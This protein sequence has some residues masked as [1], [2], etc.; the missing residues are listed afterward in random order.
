MQINTDKINFL[1]GDE[2][3]LCSIQYNPALPMFSDKMLGFLEDL[4]R[5]LMDD[6]RSRSYQ[7]VMS[8]AYW[9]RKSSLERIKKSYNTKLARIGRGVSFHIAPSNVPINFAVSM[10]SALLAGNSIVIRVSDKDYEQVSIVCDAMN[11]LLSGKHASVRDYFCIVRYPH[12]DEITSQ[13]SAMCDIRII[14]GGDETIRRIRSAA[15]PPR[16][17]EMTFAD[18]HSIALIDSDYYMSADKKEVAKGFFTDTYYT[19]Q[20]ACSSPRLVVWFGDRIE[21]A[22]ESFWKELLLLVK[23]KYRMEPVVA[24]DKYAAFCGL[25]MSAGQAR[26]QSDENYIMRVRIDELTDNVLDYKHGGGYFYE[27]NAKDIEDILPV[28][29]KR[30]QTISVLGIDKDNV[31]DFVIKNGVQGVDR[32]VDLGQTM[33]LEFVWDGYNMIENMTRIVHA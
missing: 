30:C 32:V 5:K 9:I 8:Y 2:A 27:Y 17:I 3:I 16:A 24:V 25:A 1:V 18:R 28:L 14:W 7:D 31:R 15:I 33:A 12:D 22:K 29:N 11:E 13:I 4:S 6:K 10:T 21:E 26:L 23:E 19:D 20:N